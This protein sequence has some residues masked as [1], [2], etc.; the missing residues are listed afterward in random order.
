MRNSTAARKRRPFSAWLVN[1]GSRQIFWI[2]IVSI[3]A[4]LSVWEWYGRGVNPIFFSYPTA[5]VRA[6]PEM[7]R[8]GELQE[9][10]VE[11]LQPFSV[12]WVTAIVLGITIGLL[13]GRYRAVEGLLDSQVTALYSTPT[14][15]LIPLFILWLGLGFQA[16]VAIIFLS[17]FFP[18]TV[19]TF[20]GVKSVTSDLIDIGRVERAREDQIFR[21]III[22]SSLPF[23]LTGVRLSVG[24]AVV[25]MVVAEL[26]TAISGL[27]GSIEF[28]G[29]TYQMDRLLVSVIILALLGILLTQA[30]RLLENRLMPWRS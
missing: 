15:A 24:R 1:P 20:G 23:I 10:I 3:V 22:P 30:V 2:R 7:V 16:K 11:S 4:T 14:V 5:V 29:S 28:Y 9:A 25:G 8:S 27:G 12:G 19:N 21:K 6:V 26:F 13:M 18:V 17:G